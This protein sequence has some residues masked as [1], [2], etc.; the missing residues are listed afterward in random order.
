MTTASSASDLWLTRIL[1]DP[2]SPDVRR[3]L[4]SATALHQT[5]MRLFPDDLGLHARQTAG[6]L[7]RLEEQA[8]T[9]TILM[10]S[11]LEPRLENLPLRYGNALS[12]PLTPLLTHLQSGTP[13]RYRITANAIRRLGKNPTTP[14]GRPGQYLPLHGADAEEWWHRQSATC[15]IT[16]HTVLATSLPS[17]RGTRTPDKRR[18]LHARTRFD[19]TGTVTDPQ[20]LAERIRTGIGRGKS[21]G[22][23]MLSVAPTRRAGEGDLISNH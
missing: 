11:I 5:L 9:R 15:G 21:Y 3:D 12:K 17:A 18:I 19:G 14:N 8:E 10:Q 6:V 23:G 20:Q 1:L 7:F 4:A 16:L 22:C 2:R 13:I